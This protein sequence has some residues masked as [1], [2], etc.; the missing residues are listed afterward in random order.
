MY[1]YLLYI[2]EFRTDHITLG[3]AGTTRKV[4]ERKLF[5]LETG[6]KPAPT[7]DYAPVDD[8]EDSMY[9]EQVY[10]SHF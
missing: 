10:L 6:E 4:Y 1:I 5:E 2:I 8:D 7:Y 3:I 9:L